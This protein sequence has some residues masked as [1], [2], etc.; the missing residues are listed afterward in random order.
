MGTYRL[1]HQFIKEDI[2]VETERFF[3]FQK[4]AKNTAEELAKTKLKWTKSTIKK[5]FYTFEI[6]VSTP[7]ENNVFILEPIFFE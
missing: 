3:T 1:K 2:P 5:G 6:Q 7:E 4:K